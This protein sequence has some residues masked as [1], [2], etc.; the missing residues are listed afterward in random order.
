[1]QGLLGLQP[2]LVALATPQV[3]TEILDAT[4]EVYRCWP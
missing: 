4:V 1:L 2:L 3:V